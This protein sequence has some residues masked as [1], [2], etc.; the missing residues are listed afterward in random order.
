MS[1]L[2]EP[3]PVPELIEDIKDVAT[4]ETVRKDPQVVGK[5]CDGCSALTE[6][7]SR[8]QESNR[9]LKYRYVKLRQ[10]VKHIQRHSKISEVY[11][12]IDIYM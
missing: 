1:P 9:K 11:I 8:L 6:R 5:V 12:F 7:L 10:E 3:F 2:Q 4:S